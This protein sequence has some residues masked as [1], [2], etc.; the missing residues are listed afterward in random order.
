MRITMVMY[1]LFRLC[2]GDRLIINMLDNAEISYEYFDFNKA[3]P[4]PDRI[5]RILAFLKGIIN[6]GFV[7][8]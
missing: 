1:L 4:H 5:W 7:F 3:S 6:L 2:V 8:I